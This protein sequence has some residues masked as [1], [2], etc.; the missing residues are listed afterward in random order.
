[1][2]QEGELI[3]VFSR[4]VEMGLRLGV[5]RRSPAW[6]V[7]QGYVSRTPQAPAFSAR[8]EAALPLHS[9]SRFRP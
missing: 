6:A 3:D 9:P 8:A 5:G 4:S 7:E 1:M 2:R